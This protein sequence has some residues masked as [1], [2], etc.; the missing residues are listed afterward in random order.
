PHPYGSNLSCPRGARTRAPRRAVRENLPRS[1]RTD[2]SL[3]P[4]DGDHSN[5]CP[6]AGVGGGMTMARFAY[7]YNFARLGKAGVRRTHRSRP[8]Y[9][10]D[11]G[12]IHA[13][14]SVIGALVVP[15]P[16][17]GQWQ[18]DHR[19][20]PFFRVGDR[21]AIPG[22]QLKGMVRSL[23]EALTGSCLSVLDDGPLHAR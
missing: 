6:H 16:E 21:L 4:L 2:S 11:S 17:R 7:P 18:D 22:S 13:V 12:R 15:D 10:G 19:I 14:F 23:Y 8:R 3:Y 9:A 20:L 5:L 1:C